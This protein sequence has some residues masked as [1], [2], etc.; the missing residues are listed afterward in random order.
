MRLRSQPSLPIFLSFELPFVPAEPFIALKW[1]F[2]RAV[3]PYAGKSDLVLGSVP[4]LLRLK[5]HFNL[6]FSEYFSEI[7]LVLHLK[8]PGLF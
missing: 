8:A 7:D 6:R 4:Q 5:N 1:K 3:F 2:Q